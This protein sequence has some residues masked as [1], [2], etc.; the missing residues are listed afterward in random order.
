LV[1]IYAKKLEIWVSELHFGE[2]RRNARPWWW[3]VGLGKPMIDFVLALSEL[4]FYLTV[5]ELRG[6]I[7]TNNVCVQYHYKCLSVQN[8]S[9][10]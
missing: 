2:V 4:F 9:T 6:Y 8:N 1:D 7:E 10:Q 3:L 5:P